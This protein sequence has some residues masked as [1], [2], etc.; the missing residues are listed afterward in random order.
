MELLDQHL[1]TRKEWDKVVRGWTVYVQD[2]K[3]DAESDSFLRR[4][5]AYLQHDDFDRGYKDLK[6]ARKLGSKE[7]CTALAALPKKQVTAFK[8]RLQ[9]AIADAPAC[10]APVSSFSLQPSE[11]AN[12]FEVQVYLPGPTE[13][14]PSKRVSRAEFGELLKREFSGREWG[15][16]FTYQTDF[17]LRLS[18]DF[19]V[20]RDGKV[21]C[22]SP[23]RGWD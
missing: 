17:P 9:R 18:F 3:D 2:K 10:E 5:T 14:P 6:A 7:G 13:R 8:A 22:V 20:G 11:N 19:V 1:R 16:R 4:G 23:V 12:E 15:A 21:K